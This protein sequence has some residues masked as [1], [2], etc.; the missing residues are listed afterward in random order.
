MTLNSYLSALEWHLDNGAD[1]AWEDAAVNRILSNRHSREG[2]N[3]SV[4]QQIL[5]TRFHGH[6]GV[7][8]TSKVEKQPLYQSP[9]PPS[10]ISG[11]IA[12]KEEA[13]KLAKAANTLDELKAAIQAFDGLAIKT[14]ATQIV[15][16]D[17]NPSASVM[18]IGDAPE[19]E[20]DRVGKPFV[21]ESGQL[22][23]KILAC[24]GL[25]RTADDMTKAVYVSNILNWRPPGNRTPTPVECDL[26][27]PFIE[28][29][30]QLVKPKFLILCG[31]ASAQTLLGVNDTL[32]KLRGKFHDYKTLT[33]DLASD[34]LPIPALVTFSPVYLLK[35]P[36]QKRA[37]WQDMLMLR[38]RMCNISLI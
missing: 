35:N 4:Q 30:I 32:P 25:D 20:E 38:Q 15:F 3:P 2:G 36:T 8:F 6:D 33:T 9:N 29:H 17:G 11:S 18:L 7:D 21:G 19:S 12:A 5:D 24:I 16:A 31:K 10:S 28:R 14:T 34:A 22:L 23:D 1:G 26:S 27:L 37:V 13:I